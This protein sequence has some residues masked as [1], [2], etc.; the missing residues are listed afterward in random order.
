MC[1]CDEFSNFVCASG[2]VDF[3]SSP[4]PYLSNAPHPVSLF[5][6]LGFDSAEDTYRRGH[7]PLFKD[8]Y[9]SHEC[10]CLPRARSQTQLEVTHSEIVSHMSGYESFAFQPHVHSFGL[11]SYNV[12]SMLD[13]ASNKY[14][15]GFG[16]MG[17]RELFAKQFHELGPTVGAFQ[18]ARSKRASF[19]TEDGLLFIVAS[20]NDSGNLG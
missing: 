5:E 7:D 3:L 13:N 18:E 12:Q 1:S 6:H 8:V 15:L 17:R 10:E 11:F 4:A 9:A 20:G 19:V 16:D 2:S 14:R